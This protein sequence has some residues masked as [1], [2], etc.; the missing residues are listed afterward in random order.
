MKTERAKEAPQK[1]PYSRPELTMKG[2]VTELTQQTVKDL[3]TSDGF[4]LLDQ[5]PLTN[6]S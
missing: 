6:V 4:V 5:G 2:T 3:G 1:L